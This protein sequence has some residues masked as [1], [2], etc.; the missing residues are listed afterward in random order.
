[1]ETMDA[2][3]EI[4]VLR[5][6]KALIEVDCRKDYRGMVM[7]QTGDRWGLEPALANFLAR[8]AVK[9]TSTAPQLTEGERG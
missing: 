6:A 8:V 1:M 2:A 9:A 4:M 5:V 7:R 3:T